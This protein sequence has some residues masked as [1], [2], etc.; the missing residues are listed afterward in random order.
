MESGEEATDRFEQISSS[1]ILL[2]EIFNMTD[3]TQTASIH[4]LKYST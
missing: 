3:M 2:P 1:S 4:F